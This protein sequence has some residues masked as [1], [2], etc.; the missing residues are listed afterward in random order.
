LSIFD[1]SF[2][3]VYPEISTHALNF[4]TKCAEVSKP[5]VATVLVLVAVMKEVEEAEVLE[6][7]LTR[8]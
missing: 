5:L 1:E 7:S 6:E 8:L 2:A 3:H 4:A